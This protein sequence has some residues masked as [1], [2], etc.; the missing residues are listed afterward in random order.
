MNW[1]VLLNFDDFVTVE[2]RFC[3][4]SGQMVLREVMEMLGHPPDFG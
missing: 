4:G 1:G 2:P 3:E